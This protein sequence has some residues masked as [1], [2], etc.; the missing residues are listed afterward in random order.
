MQNECA[1]QALLRNDHTIISGWGDK[2]VP[3]VGIVAR[4]ACQSLLVSSSHRQLILF[5]PG[6]ARVV[7]RLSAC[8]HVFMCSVQHSNS[9]NSNNNNT[10]AQRA[11]RC[12]GAT[13]SK[14]TVVHSSTS[15]HAV[16]SALKYTFGFSLGHFPISCSSFR[17][18]LTLKISCRCMALLAASSCL[19]EQV[20]YGPTLSSI[21]AGL[22]RRL[23]AYG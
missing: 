18:T 14:C 19:L 22:H 16:M 13:M 17:Q 3:F 8:V 12:G 1:P 10:L 20:L 11:S 4:K 15:S 9:G 5:R 7:V 21:D 2:T 6:L 23:D